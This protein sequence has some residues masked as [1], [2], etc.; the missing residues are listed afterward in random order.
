M[1]KHFVFLLLPA[2]FVL[3]ARQKWYYTG[4]LFHNDVRNPDF[5]GRVSQMWPP[6]VENSEADADLSLSYGGILC[7]FSH[8]NDTVESYYSEYLES[9]VENKDM[10]S[11]LG[12]WVYNMYSTRDYEFPLT[13]EIGLYDHDL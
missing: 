9:I 8:Y 10:L 5:E 6:A 2:N 4:K 12:S 7:N 11:F 1:W 13:F 3:S